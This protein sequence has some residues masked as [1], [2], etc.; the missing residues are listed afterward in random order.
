R[1]YALHPWRFRLGLGP[2]IAHPEARIRGVSYDGDYELAGAAAVGS[3]GATFALTPRVWVI[4][5]VAITVGYAD[6]HLRGEPASSFNVLNPAIHA[7]I[8]FDYRF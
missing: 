8:G 6:V 3:A 1:A 5:E 4:G 2:V 7:R